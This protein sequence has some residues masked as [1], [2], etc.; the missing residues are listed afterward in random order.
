MHI[1]TKS[2]DK[3]ETSLL[4]GKRVPKYDFR[5]E[6][7]G[8]VD[9]LI[10]YIGLIRDQSIRQDLKIELITI[11]D[12]LMVC[13]S[14][15]AA[16]CENCKVDLPKLEANNIRWLEGLID[17]KESHLPELNSFVIPG[18]HTT[19]SYV[20]IA[21]NVCRRAERNAIKL[22]DNAEVPDEIIQYLNRLS[23]YL[24]M[25]SRLLVQE[26]GVK[27]VIWRPKI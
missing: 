20:H 9:E 13:A 15:L 8:T 21:R 17:E 23:D 25:L 16:D 24:F 18:G 26:L 11:Q 2:G 1:Y 6:A 14:I 7:Y 22:Y 12:H 3:G 19:V 27:E 5:I 10:A 4:G